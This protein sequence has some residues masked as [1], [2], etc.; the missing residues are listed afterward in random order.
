MHKSLEGENESRPPH[1][2]STPSALQVDMIELK[3]APV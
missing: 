2:H 1:G 3:V